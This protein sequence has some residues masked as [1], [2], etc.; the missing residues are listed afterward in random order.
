VEFA[1]LGSLEAVADSA[2]VALGPHKQRAILGVLLLHANE[3]VSLDHLVEAVWGA[4]PPPS[5][6]K[7]VQVYVSQL[8]RALDQAGAGELLHTRAPGYVVTVAA[9]QPYPARF[10]ALVGEARKRA[11][12][13]ELD[14][15]A[16]LY[17]EALEIWRGPVL[18]DI[19]LEAAVL[20][21]ADRLHGL[22]LAALS[23]RADCELARGRHLQVVP[24]LEKLTTEHPL[25]E[26]LWAQLMLAL[27]RS[28]RQAEAL[29]AYQQARRALADE[30]GLSP[31]PELRQLE[32]AILTHDPALELNGHAI[33]ASVP[34]HPPPRSRRRAWLALVMVAVSAGAAAAAVALTRGAPTRPLARLDPN[35][36]GIIDPSKD[37]LVGEI[38]LETRPAA[39][40]VGD[41]SL[42]VAMQD[43]QTLLR[44]DSS[45]RTV[46]RTIGLGA[47]PTAVA[48][49]GRYVWVFCE[50]EQ[51]V[52]EVDAGTASVVRTLTLKGRVTIGP[53]NEWSPAAIAA[54]AQAAWLAVGPGLLTRI[55]AATGRLEHVGR[56]S[57]S[58]VAVGGAQCG[59][60]GVS[61]RSAARGRRTGSTR[62]PAV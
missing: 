31:S 52:T 3:V 57:A 10:T 23:E 51:T 54:D 26:H 21:S 24:E 28:G 37:A 16:S 12:E 40:A 9:D 53:P 59:R 2:P 25:H 6:S 33:P 35:S 42:W 56:G 49:G 34:P 5:A 46:T 14:A 41:G 55:D 39:I 19:K 20:S 30:V 38:S 44:L 13:G 43:D 15:A 17:E 18:A 60:S 8:R 29:A 48:A 27:Y 58:A 47:T 36:I 4:R 11:D 7:L 1:I 62:A 32:R 61:R 50:H 22:R 45:T